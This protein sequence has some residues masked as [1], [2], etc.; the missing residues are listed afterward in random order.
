MRTS[1]TMARLVWYHT[2]LRFG[3]PQKKDEGAKAA[4]AE[5][6]KEKDD[7][8]EHEMRRAMAEKK[9]ALELIEA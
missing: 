6:G 4:N 9:I 1:R 8:K 7:E 2:P 3:P 5:A